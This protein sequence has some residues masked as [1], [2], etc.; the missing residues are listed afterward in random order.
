[1][2]HC[3]RPRFLLV[4]NLTGGMGSESKVLSVIEIN[5]RCEIIISSSSDI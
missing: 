1:M 5:V 3:K 2:V 4:G